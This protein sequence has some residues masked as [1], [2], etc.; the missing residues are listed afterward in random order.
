MNFFWEGRTESSIS[1]NGNFWGETRE[2]G[3]VCAVDGRMEDEACENPFLDA[4]YVS[5]EV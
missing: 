5:V 3:G 4:C 2:E 1:L